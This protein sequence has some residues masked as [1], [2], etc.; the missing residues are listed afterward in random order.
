MEM[1]KENKHTS[2]FLKNNISQGKIS[3]V[4]LSSGLLYM[5]PLLFYYILFYFAGGVCVFVSFFLVLEAG[6]LCV[7]DLTVLEL[8]L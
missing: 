2:P 8:T 7:R 6:F 3:G 5:K 1:K 4:Y